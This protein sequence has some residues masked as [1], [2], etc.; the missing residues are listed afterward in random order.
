MSS[1]PSEI[2]TCQFDDG[3]KLQLFYKYGIHQCDDD[4]GH[5]GGVAYEAAVH[6]HVLQPL[7]VSVPRF[8]GAYTDIKTGKTLLALEYL[9]DIEHLSHAT[10]PAVA[11]SLAARWLGQFHAANQARL[12]STS[13]PFLKTYDVAYYLA[14][15]QRMSLVASQSHHRF[16]WLATLCKR[17]EECVASLLA[18]AP[19]II[20]GE[21]G[22][23]NILVRN[24]LIYPVDWESAAIGVG[25]TDLAILTDRW[26]VEIVRQCELEYQRT[27][28][29]EGAPIDF[30]RTLNAAQLYLHFL[31][32]GYHPDSATHPSYFW[33]FDPLRS[34]GEQLGLI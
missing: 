33:R 12:A 32:L 9:H 17:F 1:Y 34:A 11:M 8:Y 19:T 18:P 5:W 2:V 4:S 21:Y 26:S 15:A 22:P 10:E 20:H 6:R 7:E 27:R 23:E 3:R 25:E 16:P 31:W 30:E 13:M 14:V 28:W 29:P 24:G